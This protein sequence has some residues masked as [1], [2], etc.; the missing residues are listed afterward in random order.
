LKI[1]KLT[2]P[3]SLDDVQ[4]LELGDMVYLNGLVFTCRGLFQRRVIDEGIPPPIDTRKINVMIHVGPIVQKTNEEWKV[5]SMAPTTSN[6]YEKWGA[7]TIEKL[8]LRA[9]VGKGTMG[10]STA[11]AMRKFGCVHLTTVGVMGAMLPLLVKVKEVHWQELGPIEATWVLEAKDLG[12][13]Q[14]DIDTRGNRH[15]QKIDEVIEVRRK[16]VYKK[17]GIPESFKYESLTFP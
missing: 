3:L 10:P 13:F 16:E 8:S 14:V 1:A 12:P 11:E 4:G 7:K 6:R 5:V 17:L 15:F 9:I 2:T